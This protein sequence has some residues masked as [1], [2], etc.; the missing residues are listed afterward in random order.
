MPVNFIEIFTI[1]SVVYGNSSKLQ[2]VSDEVGAFLFIKEK[3]ESVGWTNR[4]AS[5]AA[6]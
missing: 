4:L 5:S 1:E 2:K 6:D 3:P